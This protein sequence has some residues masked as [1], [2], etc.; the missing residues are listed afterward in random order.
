MAYCN[1]LNIELIWILDEEFEKTAKLMGL[2]QLE[3]LKY[4][5]KKIDKEFYKIMKKITV[6]S[7]MKN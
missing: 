4:L 3:F 1:G 2:W 7:R 5:E 6:M